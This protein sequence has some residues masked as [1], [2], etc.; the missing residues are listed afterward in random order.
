MQ[1]CG[2]IGFWISS[3][4]V[5]IVVILALYFEHW[6]LWK[7]RNLRHRVYVEVAHH[8]EEETEKN[9]KLKNSKS[10]ESQTEGSE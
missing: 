3:G 9:N 1:L 10:D 5:T 2:G 6:R 7:A 8:L 4:I